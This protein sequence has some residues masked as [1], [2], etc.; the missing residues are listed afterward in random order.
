IATQHEIQT[1]RG[2][3]LARFDQLSTELARAVAAA[4][5]AEGT[6]L[7]TETANARAALVEAMR[8]VAGEATAIETRLRE[9]DELL[10][11][12]VELLQT[13]EDSLHWAGLGRRESGLAG[14]DWRR[15]WLE[16]RQLGGLADDAAAVPASP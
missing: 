11:G 12:H 7:T 4:P 6:R 16:L 14:A 5:G 8:A 10:K 3:T 9:A 1:V 15:A 2:G 13:A